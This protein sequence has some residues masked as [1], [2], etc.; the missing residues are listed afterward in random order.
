MGERR[1]LVIAGAGI[2]GLT[3]ALA[4]TAQGFNVVVSERAEK[5]SELGAG[6]QIAPNAGRVLAG[7]GLD[8]ALAAAAIEPTAIDVFDGPTGCLITAIPSQMFRA[9]YD[10]P[11][12]SS[13]APTCSRSSPPPPPA[14]ASASISARRWRERRPGGRDAVLARKPGRGADV[15]SADGLI[16]ADGVWSTVRQTIAGA[17]APV[18]PAVAP[19]A[20]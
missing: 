6:I 2:A 16:G 5:L 9:R 12:G 13:T 7:L 19:G 18:A 14:P 20:R 8:K 17:A 11:T 4:L 1:T 15:I 3:A 10:F